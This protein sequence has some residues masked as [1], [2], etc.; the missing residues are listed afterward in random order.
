MLQLGQIG[1]SRA[2][3]QQ[4]QEIVELRGR[5][6]SRARIARG[7]LLADG[8]RGR[9]AV[10]LVDIRLLHALQELARV[11]GERFDIAALTFG[12]NGVEGQRRFARSRDA[13]DHGQLVMRD[14]ERD[15]LKI[16][17][18]RATNADC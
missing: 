9:D 18:A 7:V 2:G 13:R 1:A 17:D 6:N 11:S 14:V 8:D 16:V 12:V 4:A 10:D 3:P 5:G 15:I